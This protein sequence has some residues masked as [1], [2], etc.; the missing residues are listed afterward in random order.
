MHILFLAENRGDWQPLEKM[1]MDEG[2]ACQVTHASSKEEFQAALKQ[3]QTR[4]DLIL[5]DFT[6]PAYSGIAALAASKKLQ[7]DTPFIFVSGTSVEEQVVES[8]KSGAVD[9]VLKDRLH[10]LGPMVRRALLEARE[11]NERRRLE[12]QLRV[13]SS[14]LEAAA[15]GIILTD[16]TGKILFANQAYCAMTGHDLEEVT[17]QATRFIES[18]KPEADL[19]QGLWKTILAGRV[20][21]GEF[22]SRR[23]DGTLYN[24]EIT[25]TPLRE[26]NGEIKIG[27]AHV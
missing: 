16:K 26:S 1:L 25:V 17:G 27:R 19:S 24:E 6:L 23:K 18:G 12:Q 7:P 21:H 22:I 4:F 15:N 20:W 3:T 14:A 5:S 2:L 8:L 13:Q 9:Y 10:R 11:R